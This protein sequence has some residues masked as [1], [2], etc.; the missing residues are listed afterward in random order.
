MSS[1]R[2]EE[3][4]RSRGAA[5]AREGERTAAAA[6][7]VPCATAAA[8]ADA[9]CTAPA[10]AADAAC[11]AAAATQFLKTLRQDL[12]EIK[13]EYSSFVD[14]EELS[15]EAAAAVDPQQ[16]QQQHATTEKK[17]KKKLLVSQQQQQEQQE[18]HQH[19]Q[20][21]KKDIV[22]EGV[23]AI[24]FRMI[25]QQEKQLALLLRF[26]RCGFTL[27]NAEEV[28]QQQAAGDGPLVKEAAAL[29]G[30]YETIEQLLLSVRPRAF[31][32][33]QV[34]HVADKL[35]LQQQQQE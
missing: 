18:G 19:Q 22:A 5:A 34:Q 3:D 16:Q 13:R 29:R 8:A 17:K 35:L 14:I 7:D 2:R 30:P 26:D 21:H 27:L 25:F 10:A 23:G 1:S 12:K 24:H 28:L 33:F 15:E 9:P 6:A 11:A 32:H 4:V 20:L 31:E